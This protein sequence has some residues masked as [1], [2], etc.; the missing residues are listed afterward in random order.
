[1]S[2]YYNYLSIVVPILQCNQRIGH[3]VNKYDYKHNILDIG[4]WFPLK[5][6]HIFSD[7]YM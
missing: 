5:I 2:V 6:S 3:N 1:M 4:V 7:V